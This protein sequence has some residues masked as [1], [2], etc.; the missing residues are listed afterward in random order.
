MTKSKMTVFTMAMITSAAVMSLRGLPMI[1]KEEFTLF[2][3]IGFATLLFLIPAALVAAELGGMFGAEEGGVYTW[4]K[5]AFGKRLGFVAI[6]LQW[7]QN[8]VWY[9]TVLAF[10]AA[11]FSYVIGADKLA[12]SGVYTG[13]FCIVFYW[14]ATWVS[15]RG[16]NLI[17]RITSYGFV[18]GTILPALVL[19]V[20]AVIWVMQG[21]SIG[22]QHLAASQGALDTVVHNHVHPR[23]FPQISGLSNIAFLSGVL[24]L[25]AGVEVHAVNANKMARPQVQYPL[26]L[27][28]T[29]IIV[30]ALFTLGAFAISAIMPYSQINVESGLLQTFQTVFN[31]INMPWG[32]SLVGILVMFGAL[33]SVTS[34]IVGPSRGLLKTAQDGLLPA[35]WAKTN[36]QGVQ[37]NILLVQAVIVTVLSGIYFI[38]KN[39]SVAFFL[40]SAM[41]I[42][43]YLI[44]YALMYA[45]GICL[46][47]KRPDL[48]RKF[49]VPG[50][51][52]GMW[53]A[54]LVG[55]GGVSFSFIV[56]F[57][58]PSQLPVGNP[59]Q[60]VL[61]VAG[62]TVI[63]SAIP[64]FIKGSR[65]A[66]NIAGS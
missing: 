24:L 56:A 31:R 9:P 16:G 65:A 66:K 61:L 45:A 10:A 57:F 6:W 11:T 40:I 23:F 42:T 13:L 52:A 4:V 51:S 7:V 41:T 25:F 63:F 60:Y 55:I 29:S 27:L 8:V 39:V 62:G 33:A 37:V 3:Y 58:P 46:R 19:L 22:F 15:L 12:N 44:M 50:G 1:A 48:T 18:A 30:F 64:F 54:G 28:L 59:A 5:E 21:N 35:F 32:V 14:M 49:R 38:T 20:L 36:A 47:Y 26:A 17:D 34:W 2:F 43:L 53:L